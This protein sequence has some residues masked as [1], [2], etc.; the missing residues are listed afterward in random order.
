MQTVPS[1]SGLWVVGCGVSVRLCLWQVTN[2]KVHMVQV[3]SS[4]FS[5]LLYVCG[6]SCAAGSQFF[7]GGWT[8]RRWIEQTWFLLYFVS[9]I[10]PVWEI[11]FHRMTANQKRLW[12]VGAAVIGIGS[13]IKVSKDEPVRNICHNF[14]MLLLYCTVARACS[15][16]NYLFVW[17][18]FL[19]RLIE[20]ISLL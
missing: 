11:M 4:A 8:R 10:T 13:L 3:A 12:G 17:I 1:K 5:V 14:V 16:K 20:H 15:D 7:Y 18:Q 6:A 19:T 9:F 2:K